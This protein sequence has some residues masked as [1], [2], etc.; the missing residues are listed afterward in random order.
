MTEFN[1]LESEA[2]S[3]LNHNLWINEDLYEKY[4]IYLKQ[5]RADH[6]TE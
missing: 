4:E 6:N 5:Y 1:K 3:L 2:Y